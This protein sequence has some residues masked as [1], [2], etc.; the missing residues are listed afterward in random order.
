M[1]A[2]QLIKVLEKLPGDTV[3]MMSSDEEGNSFSTLYEIS[4]E[5]FVPNPNNYDLGDFVELK[6]GKKSPKGAETVVVLW[7]TR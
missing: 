7:P 2:N 4:I 5:L 3:I 6:K 1:T